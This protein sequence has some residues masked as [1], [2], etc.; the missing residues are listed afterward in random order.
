MAGELIPQTQSGLGS[1]L[2]GAANLA[3]LFLPQ[4]TNTTG[5]QT[6]QDN[7]SSTSTQTG[8]TTTTTSSTNVSPDAVN[9]LVQSILEGT[10]G[11]A[12]VSSG[13]RTAGLYGS[14]T[15]QLLTNDLI[16]RAAAEG[17]KLNQSTTQ[18][19]VR[20]DTTTTT[21]NAGGQTTNSTQAVNR[22]AP[23][24]GSSVKGAAGV[25]GAL[26]LIPT[27]VKNSILSGLG[28]KVGGKAAAVP[29][30]AAASQ[31]SIAQAYSDPSRG[32]DIAPGS[33]AGIGGVGTAGQSGQTVAGVGSVTDQF[34]GT[35][36]GSG[37]DLSGGDGAQD[38]G[39]SLSGSAAADA[40]DFAGDAANVD[41]SGLGD[42]ADALGGFLS[43]VG[44]TASDIGSSVGD[45]FN[46]FDFSFADGGAV[47]VKGIQQRMNDHVTKK[48]ADGGGIGAAGDTRYGNTGGSGRP[49]QS[50]GGSENLFQRTN[51]TREEAAGTAS[52]QADVMQ[53]GFIPRTEQERQSVFS[54]I[55]TV[56]QLLN[57]LLGNDSSTAVGK[58][59]GGSVSR[60][61]EK[62]KGY[63]NGGSVSSAEDSNVY[64]LSGV[65]YLANTGL[66]AKGPELVHALGAASNDQVV[67]RMI[68]DNIRPTDQSDNTSVRDEENTR[69]VSGAAGG[70]TRSATQTTPVSETDPSVGGAGVSV[71]EG[72]GSVGG[73][74]NAI[75]V[76][77][78]VGHAGLSGLASI[79]GI[80]GLS[81]V[82]GLANSQTNSQ[83]IGN[84]AVAA[85]GM[86]NPIAG[87]IAAI[88]NS[89]IQAMPTP[90]AAGG[91]STADDSTPEGTVTVGESEAVDAEGNA[92]SGVEGGNA[93]GVSGTS[94]TSSG[95]TDGAGGAGGGT[96]GAGAGASAGD[97]A[98]GSFADGGSPGIAVAQTRAD[99][100]TTAD[101]IPAMLSEG[102]YVLP[103]DVVAAIGM[104]HLDKLVAQL[105]VPADVQRNSGFRAPAGARR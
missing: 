30:T 13:Q 2:T 52:P 68:Q 79:S 75:G 83:A 89:Q 78:G 105:H 98:D 99:P 38:V 92:V 39:Y 4:N 8:G 76:S 103:A 3:Q 102:E 45:W 50:S 1:T 95:D 9:A 46:D 104:P 85:I 19:T 25:L 93:P 24:S 23:V 90:T 53:R 59:D 48:L 51:R 31:D 14:S 65:S 91:N 20:P 100:S 55:D 84:M 62:P 80:P 37:I 17:A 101:K 73:I 64:D 10:N 5:S 82:A 61:F 86:A 43:G 66:T 35:S 7:R 27:D 54:L 6:T 42:T 44:D 77:Q 29:T 88:I 16:A 49:M 97:S 87:I 47:S 63:A 18:T 21:Q 12:A 57:A 67:N 71:G 15:N 41:T 72:I 70:Q 33:A 36:A 60:P 94:T 28:I 22:A 26:Q 11:L 40:S 56:P 74:S 81:T 96:S 58:A 69:R 32:L 34:L